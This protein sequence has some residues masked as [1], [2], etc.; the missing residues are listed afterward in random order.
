MNY[1]APNDTAFLSRHLNYLSRLRNSAEIGVVPLCFITPVHTKTVAAGLWLVDIHDCSK[2][3]FLLL[4]STEINSCANYTIASVLNLLIALGYETYFFNNAYPSNNDAE[5]FSQ[6]ED[7]WTPYDP[8]TH[9]IRD[10]IHSLVVQKE[11]IVSTYGLEPKHYLKGLPK[12]LIEETKQASIAHWNYLEE[13]KLQT[14]KKPTIV[15]EV[16][17]KFPGVVTSQD[18]LDQ[19]VERVKKLEVPTDSL[20]DMVKNDV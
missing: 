20:I 14:T 9:H 19:L 15:D 16:Y 12:E 3:G 1:P 13:K 10:F 8:A 18:S 7:L 17:G 11:Q 4:D 6:E 5:D 2:A